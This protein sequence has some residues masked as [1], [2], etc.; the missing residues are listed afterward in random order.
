[1]K[2][3]VSLPA[4]DVVTSVATGDNDFAG[5]HASFISL[6]ISK[7]YKVKAIATGWASTHK[8][9]SS[10]W[11]V[12]ENSSIKEPKDLIGKKIALSS[13]RSY[14][15]TELAAKYNIPA[16]K[17]QVVVLPFDKQEQALKQGQVDA[18]E[19]LPPFLWKAVK[20]GG[21]RILITRPEVVGEEKGWPQQI[22]NVDLLKN[23]PDIV[24]AYVKAPPFFTPARRNLNRRLDNGE[25]W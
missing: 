16:D 22:V 14:T 12:L 2:R 5:T 8:L 9:P 4:P 1:M 19:L 6:G 20:G 23:R 13:A 7:G 11:L 17:V 24:R 3:P 10:A 25:Y 15:W 21:A 18:I